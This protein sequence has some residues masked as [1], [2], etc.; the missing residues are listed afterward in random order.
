M[1]K[2]YHFNETENP[3]KKG[4]F[5]EFV[6]NTNTKEFCGRDGASWGVLKLI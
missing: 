5:V 6:W 2:V 1:E 3:K 4:A